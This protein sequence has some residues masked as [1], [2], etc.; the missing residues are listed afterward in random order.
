MPPSAPECKPPSNH[1]NLTD[2]PWPV[3]RYAPA[4]IWPL[5]T[6]AGQTV[7][8]L[9]SGVDASHPQLPGKVDA[10]RDL[11]DS[12]PAA[13]F[14]CVGH[15]TGVASIITA[16]PAEGLGFTGLAPGVRILPV[17]ISEQ[18][19]VASGQGQGGSVDPA[20]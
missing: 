9:D 1:Q 16:S 20:G 19:L 14:D 12:Q 4:R 8:V 2:P 17:R 7:A 6:G 11:L 15:G 5:A 3:R 13:T 10:G 18:P